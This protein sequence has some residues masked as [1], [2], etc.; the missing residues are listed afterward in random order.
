MSANILTLKTEGTATAPRYTIMNDEGKYYHNDG[1]WGS[2][3]GCAL[4]SDSNAGCHQIHN[5]LIEQFGL[6]P[7]QQTFVVPLWITLRAE[8]KVSKDTLEEWLRK[9]TK[10][11]TDSNAGIGP[12]ENSYGCLQVFWSQMEEI[13]PEDDIS[14]E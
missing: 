6:L 5:L 13:P 3:Q 8:E 9:V 2:H 4:F 1:K 10:I 12:V 11:A 7:S 14:E